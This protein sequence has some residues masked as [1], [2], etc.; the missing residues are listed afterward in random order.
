MELYTNNQKKINSLVSK[1]AQFIIIWYGIQLIFVNYFIMSDI[2]FDVVFASLGVI[3]TIL[4]IKGKPTTWNK[5][6]AFFSWISTAIGY[7]RLIL[8][9]TGK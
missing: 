1:A 6:V 8:I 3:V 9:L 7:I 2:I 5:C 4:T